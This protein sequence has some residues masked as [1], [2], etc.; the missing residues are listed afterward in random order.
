MTD[1][2]AMDRP[3]GDSAAAGSA[4][5]PD[6]G[7]AGPRLTAALARGRETPAD[8]AALH[9]ALLSDRVLVPLTAVAA[10]TRVTEHGL[11][12]ESKA[13]MAMMTLTLDGQSA[14]PVFSS[15]EQLQAWRPDARPIPMTGTQACQAALEQGA[16]AIVLDPA[17]AALTVSALADLARGWVPVAGADLAVRHTDAAL[18][19]LAAAPDPALVAALTAA[20][21]GEHLAAARLVQGP[22]GLVLGVLPRGAADPAALAAMAARVVKAL[23]AALPEVGLDLAVVPLRG[24]GHDLLRRRGWLRRK[25]WSVRRLERPCLTIDDQR[26]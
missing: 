4:A 24:P 17:G 25:G 10:Q 3:A 8:L 16:V 6:V 20:V 21:R 12:A 14:L 23:G 1:P 26:K 5:A 11:R 22:D 7:A 19:A 2:T 13:E 18:T 15:L 9:A